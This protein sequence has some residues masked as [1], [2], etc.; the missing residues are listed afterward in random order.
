MPLGRRTIGLDDVGNVFKVAQV[1]KYTL[2]AR[3]IGGRVAVGNARGIGE[4]N[5]RCGGRGARA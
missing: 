5:N 3:N 1:D 4:G 2:K